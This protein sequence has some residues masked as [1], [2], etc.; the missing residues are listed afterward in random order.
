MIQLNTEE[1][2]LYQGCHI[3]LNFHTEL[4]TFPVSS[5]LMYFFS[6]LAF[7]VTTNGVASVGTSTGGG[8]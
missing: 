2:E 7:Y 1:R 3:Y 6:I 8:T 5:S 4:Y